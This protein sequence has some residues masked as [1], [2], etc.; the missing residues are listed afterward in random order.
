MWMEIW[1]KFKDEN[2]SSNKLCEI[3]PLLN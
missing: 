2:L 1:T 3:D